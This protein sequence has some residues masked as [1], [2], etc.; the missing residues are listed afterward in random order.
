MSY[1]LSIWRT[2]DTSEAATEAALAG[3]NEDVPHTS[4]RRFDV[5]GFIRELQAEFGGESLWGDENIVPPFDFGIAD[6]SGV[7]ANWV[8]VNVPYSRVADV[9]P[10][11]VKV[12]L[13]HGLVVFDF[14]TDQLHSSQ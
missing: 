3:M 5:R 10:K 1:D 7:P 12:A 6:F 8:G 4:M 11:R 9:L 2:T 14:Q 13:R